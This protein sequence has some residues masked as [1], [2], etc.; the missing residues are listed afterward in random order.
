MAPNKKPATVAMRSVKG[1]IFQ[2]QQQ[3]NKGK[4]KV[5][6]ATPPPRGLGGA[7]STPAASTTAATAAAAS[8]AAAAPPVDPA[9]AAA[10]EQTLRAF[11]LNG[12]FGP[13]VNP[14]RLERW[15]RAEKLGLNPP[16]EV[17]ALLERFAAGPGLGKKTGVSDKS[18]WNGRV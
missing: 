6:A 8:T 14:S 5:A 15:E 2:Q 4:G 3:L 18:L 13:C 17:K 7:A 1:G 9:A 11:D 10:A 12:K 16:K